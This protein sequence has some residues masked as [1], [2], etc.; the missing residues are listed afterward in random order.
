MIVTR[1]INFMMK[2]RQRMSRDRHINPRRRYKAGPE[3]IG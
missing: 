3:R 1:E 2:A